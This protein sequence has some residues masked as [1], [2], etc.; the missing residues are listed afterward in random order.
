MLLKRFLTIATLG[1]VSSGGNLPPAAALD[2]LRDPL[3]ELDAA[4]LSL[5]IT[6]VLNHV[7]A[8][9]SSHAVPVIGPEIIADE[10]R[11]VLESSV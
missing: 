4:G 5:H 9:N 7:I 2:E 11:R 1:E 10:I 6:R 8:S 3:V